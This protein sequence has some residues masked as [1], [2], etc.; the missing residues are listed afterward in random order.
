MESLSHIQ[1]I[2][3]A[4]SLIWASHIFKV[5]W[6]SIPAYL[7]II[8][9]FLLHNQ[10]DNSG[11]IHLGVDLVLITG[12]SLLT[13]LSSKPSFKILVLL[14]GLAFCSLVYPHIDKTF[15][16][17][18]AVEADKN[19]E[20]LVSFND[21][22]ELESWIEDKGGMYNITFP[23]FKPNDK[24]GLLD[25]YLSIDAMDGADLH[26]LRQQIIQ[27]QRVRHVEINEVV[28]RDVPVEGK[29][30]ASS[31]AYYNDPL[32]GQ[33]WQMLQADYSSYFDKLQ[34]ISKTSTS[35]PVRLAILD[36]G[37]EGSHE[38]IESNYQSISTTYDKD[39]RG[40][41]THCAGIA[42]AVSGN[43]IGIMSLVAPGLNIKVSGVKV[44]NTLGIGTQKEIISGMIEAIDNGV[45]VISLSLGGIT[46]ESHE[47]AYGEAVAYAAQHNV[48]VVVAAGNSATNAANYSPA[49]TPGVI[50]VGSINNK[51]QRSRFSNY[52]DYIDKGIYAPGEDIFSTYIKN[53]Y[54]VYSGT[55]MAAPLIAG[56]VAVMRSIDPDL[57]VNRAYSYLSQG[58]DRNVQGDM[59]F[60]P[61]KAIKLLIQDLP[62][63]ASNLQQ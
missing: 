15:T 30:Y 39:P 12:L 56:F 32:A 2:L 42:A 36:T 21:T 55:S 3:I 38:D 26:K 41:G 18:D 7:L 1:L 22:K 17:T 49:N 25:E 16:I 13:F 35:D 20:L 47:K 11:F 9:D 50:T 28:H 43:N 40:H 57:D 45:D 31:S 4:F 23:I 51:G 14:F 5:K 8:G 29:T 6:L 19:A 27:D 46:S 59:I 48:I 34:N 63:P 24:S 10:L 60:S 33:Q 52:L 44:L 37:I 61:D 54:K 62:S 53:D 58:S